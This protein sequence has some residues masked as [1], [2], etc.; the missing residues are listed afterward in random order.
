[1][2]CNGSQKEVILR[3]G[4]SSLLYGSVASEVLRKAPIPIL[5]LRPIE[6]PSSLEL[7]SQRLVQR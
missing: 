2:L 4:L 3:S 7:E 6:D 5:L 1:M